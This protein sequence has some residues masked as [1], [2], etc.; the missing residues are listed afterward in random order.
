MMNP[1]VVSIVTILGE[2]RVYN[3]ETVQTAHRV[4]SEVH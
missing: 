3:K 4:Y 1:A 2:G